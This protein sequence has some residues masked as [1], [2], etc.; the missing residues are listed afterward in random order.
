MNQTEAE[1][2]LEAF[3]EAGGFVQG[4]AKDALIDGTYDLEAVLESFRARLERIKT[5]EEF[6]P[7]R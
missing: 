3:R 7:D 5:A 4:S 1:I 2:L 6:R